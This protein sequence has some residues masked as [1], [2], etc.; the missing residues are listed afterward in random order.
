M[1]KYVGETIRLKTS[2]TN[3][4]TGVV[5]TPNAI[6]ISIW[7]PE[8]TGTPVVTEATMLPVANTPGTY[9]YFWQTALA[10]PSEPGSYVFRITVVGS[11]YT[12]WEFGQVN[13]LASRRS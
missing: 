10:T 2:V 5:V 11:N 12:N 4:D 8:L 9:E 7:P 1:A 3:A 13:L 6:T